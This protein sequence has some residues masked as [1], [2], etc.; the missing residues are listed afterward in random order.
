M[1]GFKTS[2]RNKWEKSRILDSRSSDY[3]TRRSFLR[4][5]ALLRKV[6]SDFGVGKRVTSCRRSESLLSAF[7]YA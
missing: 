2:D 1:I 3:A 4:D 7:Y 6:I 5:L